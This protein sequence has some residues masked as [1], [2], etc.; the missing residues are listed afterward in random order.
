[1]KKTLRFLPA[2]LIAGAAV[3]CLSTDA[4]GKL[5]FF[6]ND[7]GQAELYQT[8]PSGSYKAVLDNCPG[9]GTS[10]DCQTGGSIACKVVTCAPTTS[11]A[12]L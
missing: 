10:M 12:A 9:G 7:N 3:L 6:S 1:M 4:N 11:T 5:A 2:L 8:L